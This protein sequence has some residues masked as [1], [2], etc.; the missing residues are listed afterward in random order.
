M[1]KVLTSQHSKVTIVDDL[2]SHETN[3]IYLSGGRHLS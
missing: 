2:I 3:C 1:P